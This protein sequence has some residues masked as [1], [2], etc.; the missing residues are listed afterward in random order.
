MRAGLREAVDR[1]VDH[2]R[3]VPKDDLALFET[4]V[5]LLGA[6]CLLLQASDTLAVTSTFRA[7][8]PIVLASLLLYSSLHDSNRLPAIRVQEIVTRLQAQDC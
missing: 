5:A 8:I 3:A 7:P 6:S 1:A 4:A 2:E